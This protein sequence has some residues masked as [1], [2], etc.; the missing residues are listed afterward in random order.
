MT[1]T[2]D[3]G[4]SPKLLTGKVGIVTG[5]GSPHG[6]GRS[7]VLSLAL[8]GAY[9]VYAT[10]LTVANIPSLQEE[11]KNAGSTCEVHGAILDVTSEEQTVTVLKDIIAKYGRLD[12]YFANAGFGSYKSLQDTD[13][14]YYD[15]AISV[16]QRSF[17]LAL[18]YGGQA[19]SSTTNEKKH[20]GG[21]IVVTSS[22]AGVAGAVS[23]LAYSTAKAAVAHMIK[24]ASVQL[25]ATH[26]R[27]N[28]IAPGFVNTSIAATSFDTMLGRFVVGEKYYYNRIPE[29]IEIANIGVFLASDL[30]ASVNAQNIVADSGKT[31][32]AFGESIIVSIDPMKPL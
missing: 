19:M 11:A 20:P 22:M 24:S 29:P 9:A 30:S 12:F 8:A 7:L 6:I 31:T 21:S 5:A 2:I 13:S 18:K 15:F 17:F 28:S 25:S 10:D 32:A 23:D 26:V 4:F 14:K 3:T 16:M 27:V 1:S